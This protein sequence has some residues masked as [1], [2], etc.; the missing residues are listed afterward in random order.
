MPSCHCAPAS[1]RRRRGALPGAACS[2]TWHWR[3]AVVASTVQ[4]SRTTRLG[5]V[6]ASA[7][8]PGR[9][10]TGLVAAGA[11]QQ[12]GAAAVQAVQDQPFAGRVQQRVVRPGRDLVQTAV[13]RPGHAGAALRDLAAKGLIGNDVDPGPQRLTVGRQLEAAGTAA[14][15]EFVRRLPGKRLGWL[16]LHQCGEPRRGGPWRP[17]SCGTPMRS[18]C[19][20]SGRP[21]ANQRTR[22]SRLSANLVSFCTAPSDS[23]CSLARP[24]CCC[25]ASDRSARDTGARYEA[26]SA[27]RT[28][29]STGSGLPWACSSAQS[30]RTIS[31]PV[32]SAT[33]MRMMGASPD[34]PWR[35]SASRSKL[36]SS[37]GTPSRAALPRSAMVCSARPARQAPGARPA[38]WVRT[39][40]MV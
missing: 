1:R 30:S 8:A 35:H 2:S 31:T 36:P 12:P 9:W 37:A 29:M 38:P 34:T 15:V 14:S 19:W 40:A 20:A 28:T 18:S 23:T 33:R 25:S 39:A 6:K 16:P 24:R 32:V 11:A 10:A 26:G 21:S 22:A 13:A 5:S 7:V 4:R 27:S 17:V 3:T